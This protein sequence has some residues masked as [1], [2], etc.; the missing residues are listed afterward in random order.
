M[1]LEMTTII[2]WLLVADFHD[3]SQETSSIREEV[4]AEGQVSPYDPSLIESIVFDAL[5]QVRERLS[6]KPKEKMPLA[7]QL[8]IRPVLLG[9]GRPSF[10]LSVE[11]LGALASMGVSIDFDPY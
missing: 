6:G 5:S 8:S 2:R 3:G 9:E 1:E 4:F 7:M 11:A 10:G